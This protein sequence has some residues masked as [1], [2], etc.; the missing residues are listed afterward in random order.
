MIITGIDFETT[1]LDP[2]KDRVVQ[3]AAAKLHWESKRIVESFEV[4]LHS[5]HYPPINPEAAAVNGITEEF[6][7]EFG[8]N[9]L[10]EWNNL[11]RFMRGSD[12][13]CAQNGHNFD[14]I[15]LDNAVKFFNITPV[16]I[17]RIDS[18][19]DVNYPKHMTCRRLQHLALEH[20]VVARKAHTALDD[21]IV[22]LEVVA[23]YDIQE[24][25]K[26]AKSQLV[27]VVGLVSYDDNHLVKARRFRWNPDLKRWEKQVKEFDLD[28]FLKECNF[29]TRME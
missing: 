24:I 27:T 19:V 6:L 7:Q 22:M 17:Q 8:R 25:I 18:S 20:G 11:H 28:N 2:S 13:L 5:K 29:E 15:F 1:G 4:H 9:P 3:M 10:I 16:N 14:Y 21:V 12:A 26:R 23:K